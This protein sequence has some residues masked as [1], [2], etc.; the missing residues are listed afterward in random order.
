M[1]KDKVSAASKLLAIDIKDGILLNNETLKSLIEKNSQSKN[2][3]N[4]VLL[5]GIP[6]KVHPIIFACIK[7]VIIRTIAE[8]IEVVLLVDAANTFNSIN[9]KIF[10][11]NISILCPSISRFVKACCATPAW[12]FVIGNAEVRSNE[13]TTQGN[14]VTMAFYAL[15]IALLVMMMI[16]LLTTKCHDIKIVAFADDF[17]AAGKL[18]YLLQWWTALLEIGP[19]FGNFPKF[20]KLW[21]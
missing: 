1:K 14:P 8:S 18:K 11:H 17:S 21:L 19:K 5:T 10:F 16:Q 4:D 20:T 12:L 7:E 9:R 15:S 6:Q 2:A 3:N 13:G